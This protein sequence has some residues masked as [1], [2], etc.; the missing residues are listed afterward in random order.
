MNGHRSSPC[1]FFWCLE[2]PFSASSLS[3]IQQLSEATLE[4]LP[5]QGT[6][7]TDHSELCFL[8][9]SRSSV[10]IPHNCMNACKL[11]LIL[12]C[13][14]VVEQFCFRSRDSKISNLPLLRFKHARYVKHYLPI[15]LFCALTV[16][17][18]YQHHAVLT[19]KR[20]KV[21]KGYICIIQ[22]Q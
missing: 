22:Q 6:L 14:P 20:G 15:F 12:R 19:L 21:Q 13:T 18:E 3:R 9:Q 1:S 2:H 5:H 10:F 11:Q 16:P 4:L 17:V 7:W 8:F